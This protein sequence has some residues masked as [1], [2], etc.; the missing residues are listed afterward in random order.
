VVERDALLLLW[1]DGE[2]LWLIRTPLKSSPREDT[3]AAP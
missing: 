3:A 1:R 2:A